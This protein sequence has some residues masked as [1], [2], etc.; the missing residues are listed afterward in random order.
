MVG[1]SINTVTKLLIDAGRV[2]A[3]FQHD[4]MRGLTCKRLQLDEIWG[5]I[6]AKERN[7]PT[8]EKPQ[9]NMGSIWTWIAIDADTKL[10]PSWLV[11]LR[12]GEHAVAFVCDLA[13]RLTNR[14][15]ITTDGAEETFQT[16]TLPDRVIV[17]RLADGT[18]QGGTF[19][20]VGLLTK[21]RPSFPRD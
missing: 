19:G 15:H 20:H 14:V 5:F 12:D 10:V 9:P 4:A 6:Y 17:G 7:V 13:S 8:V 11:G 1:V 3:R 16:E 2:C 18:E 21:C